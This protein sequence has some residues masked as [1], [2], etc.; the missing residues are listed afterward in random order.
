MGSKLMVAYYVSETSSNSRGRR[1]GGTAHEVEFTTSNDCAI[2][3]TNCK[4]ASRI[5]SVN[6]GMSLGQGSM[7]PLSSI[8]TKVNAHGTQSSS[9]QRII[10]ADRLE[11]NENRDPLNEDLKS[12][13][14]NKTVE[15][16]F[17]ETSVA[18]AGDFYGDNSRRS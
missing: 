2:Y 15:F 5:K 18:G 7:Y 3:A 10:E 11:H 4:P 16:E 6:G 14:I 9:E 12:R 1:N 17:H 8:E 13:G